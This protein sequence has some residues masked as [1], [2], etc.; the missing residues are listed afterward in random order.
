[1]VR[2]GERGSLRPR[3]L[4]AAACTP[5]KASSSVRTEFISGLKQGVEDTRAR[6]IGSELT[7]RARTRWRSEFGQM[8]YGARSAQ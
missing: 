8:R 2:A 6:S 1:M 3:S 7:R 5:R 4:R